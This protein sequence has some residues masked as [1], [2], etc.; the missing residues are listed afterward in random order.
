MT[1]AAYCLRETEKERKTLARMSRYKKNG[2]R[3]NYVRLPQTYM[4]KKELEKMNGEIATM[5]LGAKYSK[6]EFLKFSDDLKKLYIENLCK[7][8][9][10]RQGDIGKFL[11]FSQ[12]TFNRLS[13]KLFGLDS[14]IYRY[15]KT[16]SPKW[17]EF[18]EKGAAAAEVP[19]VMAEDNKAKSTVDKLLTPKP[20]VDTLEKAKDAGTWPPAKEVKLETKSDGLPPR[21]PLSLES[22]RIRYV[23]SVTDAF[24]E[25]FR[26]VGNDK[27]FAINIELY[28]PVP[29]ADMLPF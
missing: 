26:L 29:T 13:A 1:D 6:E 22:L 16:P 7:Q 9:E 5:S 25:V 10:A 17:R 21:Q 19:V 15:G 20:W 11:G 12:P 28:P 23:G 4:T 24:N 18:L 2:S 8:Y 27:D 14:K 3:T